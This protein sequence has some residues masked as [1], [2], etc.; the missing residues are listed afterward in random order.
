MVARLM[1]RASAGLLQRRLKI[2]L[3]EIVADEQQRHLQLH[4][5]LNAIEPPIWRLFWVEET[6]TLDCLH[7]IPALG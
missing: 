7:E 1:R 3:A 2:G 4:V 5:S 6:I